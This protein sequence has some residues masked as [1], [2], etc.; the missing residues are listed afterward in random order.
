MSQCLYNGILEIIIPSALDRDDV[1]A[2]V[3]SRGAGLRLYRHQITS[4][5]VANFIIT[6]SNPKYRKAAQRLRK[7]FIHNG[8][9]EKRRTSGVL[10]RS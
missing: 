10:C 3:I 8:G 6:V 1:A 4:Q 7:T 2:R 9:V 5:R